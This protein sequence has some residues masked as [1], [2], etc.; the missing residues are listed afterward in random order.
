MTCLMFV[1]LSIHPEGL[2]A[3]PN[4]RPVQ[5]HPGTD[6]PLGK[7]QMPSDAVIL[8]LRQGR[9][10]WPREPSS[11]QPP[12]EC[13]VARHDDLG[14]EPFTRA[15]LR[16]P[17]EGAPACFVVEQGLER[18]GQC[19]D[20]AERNQEAAPIVFDHLWDPTNAGRDARA[21]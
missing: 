4:T 2:T 14:G 19:G 11:A 17:G 8:L 13:F 16:G 1:S 6:R 5:G 21:A 9:R 20:V 15:S 3:V 7:R 12:V 18:A 10:Q